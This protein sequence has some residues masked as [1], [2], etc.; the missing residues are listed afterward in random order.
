MNQLPNIDPVNLMNSFPFNRQG[1]G[2]NSEN[3]KRK[4]KWN[5]YRREVKFQVLLFHVPSYLQSLPKWTA[6][7]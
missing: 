4:V 6:C 5:Y 2:G 1:Q 7:T 3:F